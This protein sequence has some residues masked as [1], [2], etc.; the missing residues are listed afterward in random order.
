MKEKLKKWLV[1]AGVRAVKAA[2]EG[3]VAVL[4]TNT[5]FI[6]DVNWLAVLSG[7][8][9]GAVLSLLFSIK[10]IPEVDDGSSLYKI[11]E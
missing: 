2:A 3:A 11:V 10:G 8:I 5:L 6:G 1:A 7:A 4:G 9:M